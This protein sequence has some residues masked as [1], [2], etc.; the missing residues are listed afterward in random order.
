MESLEGGKKKAGE[1]DRLLSELTE[2][3]SDSPL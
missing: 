3:V 2:V 1:N